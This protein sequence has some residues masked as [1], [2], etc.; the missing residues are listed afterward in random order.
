MTDQLDSELARCPAGMAA[1]LLG[2]T[3]QT[4]RNWHRQGK[5]AA[6]PLPNGR[7]R[8]DV[9]PFVGKAGKATR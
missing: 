4:V 6:E 8:Y 9:R 3:P 1:R 7:F 5:I 2:V